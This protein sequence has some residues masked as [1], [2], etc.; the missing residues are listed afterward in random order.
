M[1]AL[2]V[3]PEIFLQKLSYKLTGKQQSECITRLLI[4]CDIDD[5]CSLSEERQG[6]QSKKP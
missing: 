2:M 1:K 5:F 3:M 6:I 4:S